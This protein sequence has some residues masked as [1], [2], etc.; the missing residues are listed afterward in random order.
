MVVVCTRPEPPEAAGGILLFFFSGRTGWVAIGKS[1][2]FLTTGRTQGF[3]LSSRYAP[4]P[5]DV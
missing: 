5:W 1:R 4:I 2:T 3:A